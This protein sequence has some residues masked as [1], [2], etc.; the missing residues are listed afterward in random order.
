[1]ALEDWGKDDEVLSDDWGA[2]DDVL[3]FGADDEPLAKPKDEPAGLDEANIRAGMAERVSTLGGNVLGFAETAGEN[4]EESVF[5]LGGF[6]ITPGE[7]LSGEGA[8]FKYFNPS[9]W[10][11]YKANGGEKILRDAQAAMVNADFGYVEGTSWEQV[12]DSPDLMTGVQR[13]AAFGLETGLVSLPDMAAAVTNAPVYFTSRAEEIA[14][15]RAE[16]DGRPGQPT[17]QDLAIGAT[18]AAIVTAS[19]RF[20]AEKIFE[21]FVP[22]PDDILNRTL[23]GAA[24]EGG[25]EFLQEGVIE[26]G[27]ENLGTK[28]TEGKDWVEIAKEGGERGLQGAVGG[29]TVGGGLGLAG[30]ITDKGL[31]I[32]GQRYQDGRDGSGRPDPSP[33]DPVGNVPDFEIKTIEENEG[34]IERALAG[35][36]PPLDP[37]FIDG[38]GPSAPVNPDGSMTPIDGRILPDPRD[39]ETADELAWDTG[40]ES[41]DAELPPGARKPEQRAEDVDYDESDTKPVESGEMPSEQTQGEAW[42][43]VEGERVDP[44]TGEILGNDELDDEAVDDDERSWGPDG[45]PDMSEYTDASGNEPDQYEPQ[46]REEKLEARKKLA[47]DVAAN[48]AKVQGEKGKAAP[49]W[50]LGDRVRPKGQEGSDA[51]ANVVEFQTDVDGAP[52]VWVQFTDP[53]GTDGME[54]WYSPDQLESVAP[55]KGDRIPDAAAIDAAAAEAATS[56]DNDLPAPSEAQIEAENYKKGHFNYD[57]LGITIENPAGSKRKPKWPQLKHHYGY[58]KGTVGADGDHVDAFINKKNDPSDTPVFVINQYDQDTGEFDEHKV[59]IG[60]KDEKAA[61]QAYLE[62]YTDDWVAPEH[63]PMATMTEFKKW[64]DEGDTTVEY[65]G[66]SQKEVRG[67]QASAVATDRVRANTATDPTTDDLVTFVRKL[68]GINVTNQSDIPAASLEGFNDANKTVGLPGIAQ[69]GDRGMALSELTEKLWEAGYINANDETLAIN[70]LH[71]A[72]GREVFSVQKVEPEPEPISE[73]DYQDDAAAYEAEQ[74]ERER[75]ELVDAYSAEMAAYVTG[76]L[77][78][79]KVNPVMAAAMAE[80]LLLDPQAAEDIISK[81]IPDSEVQEQ[82]DALI[83]TRKEERKQEQRQAAQQAAPAAKP[84]PAD[85]GA[86]SDEGQDTGSPEEGIDLDSIVLTQDGRSGRV[87]GLNSEHALVMLEGDKTN[88]KIPVGD[89][90]L[91]PDAGVIQVKTPEERAAGETPDLLENPPEKSVATKDDRKKAREVKPVELK[92]GDKVTVKHG[93]PAQSGAVISTETRGGFDLV[94]VLGTNG[95]EKEFYRNQVLA[96]GETAIGKRENAINQIDEID[97]DAISKEV[98]VEILVNDDPDFG[99]LMRT[100]VVDWF[101]SGEPIRLHHEKTT[102]IAGAEGKRDA[103]RM[104]SEA[105]PG[106]FFK[107][108]KFDSD[109]DDVQLDH[110][111]KTSFEQ[112]SL[113]PYWQ[114]QPIDDIAAE[115]KESRARELDWLSDDEWRATL[116]HRT[117]MFLEPQKDD[118]FNPSM[119][120]EFISTDEAAQRLEEWKEFARGPGHENPSQPAMGN[121]DKVILS[122]F[123]ATGEWAK[124]WV[125]AGYDVRAIDLKTD[126]VDVMDIDYTWLLDNGFLDVNVYGILAACPCTDFAGS[127]ARDWKPGKERPSSKGGKDFIGKTHSSVELVNHTLDLIDL[128]IPSFWAIENPIGRMKKITGVPS[129]RLTFNPNNFGDPYTKKT[130]IYG[131]FDANLPTANVEP[132]EGSL[133]HKLGSSD[134]R[135]GGLRSVTPEGFAYAFFMANNA[136]TKPGYLDV[137]KEYMAMS[138]IQKKS[139]LERKNIYRALVLGMHGHAMSDRGSEYLDKHPLFAQAYEAGEY[140][141]NED[142]RVEPVLKQ[143]ELFLLEQHMLEQA[144][145]FKGKLKEKPEIVFNRDADNEGMKKLFRDHGPKLQKKSGLLVAKLKK[146]LKAAG[147]EAT[148]SKDLLMERAMGWRASYD[149]ANLPKLPPISTAAKARQYNAKNSGIAYVVKANIESTRAQDKEMQKI[150]KADATAIGKY[151]NGSGLV[152]RDEY[153]GGKTELGFHFTSEADVESFLAYWRENSVPNEVRS[154]SP[155]YS[156]NGL[157]LFDET[158]ETFDLTEK[159]STAQ[160]LADLKA[161]KDAKRS[162]LDK[163]EPSLSLDAPDLFN[164]GGYLERDMFYDDPLNPTEGRRARQ[165]MMTPL[166]MQNRHEYQKQQGFSPVTLREA[167]QIALESSRE[168]PDDVLEGIEIKAELDDQVVTQS[169]KYWLDDI[170]NRILE[171]NKL[172]DCV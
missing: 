21:Q 17:S 113:N 45:R 123:D 67:L 124:P 172:R 25:T 9:E 37:D 89:L 28:S 167:P 66:A 50:K 69:T 136:I 91:D 125:E 40:P 133:M 75:Q 44:E 92:P 39:A 164:E 58:I 70:L 127:G 79:D 143:H 135:D 26:Y 152:K 86:R 159:K 81:N 4:V 111:I 42:A 36:P 153:E 103:E 65:E 7:P 150:W 144:L 43:P 131:N 24:G 96:E 118:L 30:G 137:A 12:K 161:K 68:G 160:E 138:K 132:T 170:D 169:G 87:T 48:Q 145:P 99:H 52:M 108:T 23:K 162:G 112:D 163:P 77:K 35:L 154:P 168:S 157:G 107:L 71:E 121:N 8:G 141:A 134:E 49:E 34:A 171:I 72:K 22:G 15:N 156:N 10:A 51:E 78:L 73:Q 94:R 148:G 64:L 95:Q 62:N 100:Y 147:V 57:G 20:G 46:S 128:L 63:I 114:T 105:H 61:R 82:L 18:A 31:E 101:S 29:G 166:L 93:D 165:S 33:D 142:W 47:A 120:K 2:D 16:A 146:A 122:L 11:D 115:R 5:G 104:F 151:F 6:G 59:M 130:Q 38:E 106:Q 140:E 88:T 117:A 155:T 84:A 116:D 85:E 102:F 149:Y 60:F 139:E 14:Q 97:W 13:L 3:D 74:I 109:P 27:A 126:D 119:D 129:P 19:E 83:R 90:K 80:A 41:T 76:E 32:A 158:E 110:W 56:P 1:M 53:D 55:Q 98:G 54:E